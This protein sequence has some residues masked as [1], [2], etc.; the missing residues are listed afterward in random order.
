[1][2]V[3]LFNGPPR[4][5]KD[6]C[7]KYLTDNYEGAEHYKLSRFLKEETLRRLQIPVAELEAPLQ[8]Y[9]EILKDTPLD[10][11]GGS[12]PRKAVIKMDKTL[13]KDFGEGYLVRRF[14][15]YAKEDKVYVLSDSGKPSEL[16]I[17]KELTPVGSLITVVRLSRGNLTFRGDSRKYHRA[18]EL[19][20]STVRFYDL[21]NE[22]EAGI[23]FDVK[24]QMK[25]HNIIGEMI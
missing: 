23:E 1:M 15:E 7:T 22:G 16:E 10:V 17:F 19:E 5:G 14:F 24:L 13:I 11:F 8:T 9:F 3:I 2:K 12:T 21:P 25:L 20:G 4:S 6:T 18:F